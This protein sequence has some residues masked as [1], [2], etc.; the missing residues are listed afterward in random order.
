MQN[1]FAAERAVLILLKFPLNVLAIFCCCVILTL[2]FC[3]LKS[4][5]IN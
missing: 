1:F 4:D 2:T 5:D 3:A